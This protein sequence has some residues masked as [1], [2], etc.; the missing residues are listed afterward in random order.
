VTKLSRLIP[1]T[2]V[3]VVF[4]VAVGVAVATQSDAPKS[5]LTSAAQKRKLVKQTL[6]HEKARSVKASQSS[7]VA[8]LGRPRTS[9]DDVPAPIADALRDGGPYG[10]NVA[11][12]RRVETSAGAVWLAPGASTICLITPDPTGLAH[13][14]GVDCKTPAEVEH[15]EL[16]ASWVQ[17]NPD[18]GLGTAIVTVPDEVD[19]VH[20]VKSNG[21][22]ATVAA[23]HNVVVA[24]GR[25]LTDLR[26]TTHAGPQHARP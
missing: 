22:R 10:V 17:G 23:R 24:R 2:A 3:V 11:L 1:V 25:N 8:E 18:A 15:G 6:R 5:H 14:F 7:A 16:L 21:D 19:E 12:A 13:G 20:V 4:V 9:D 26:F